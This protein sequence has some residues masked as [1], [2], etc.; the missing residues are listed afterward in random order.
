MQISRTILRRIIREEVASLVEAPVSRTVD[1]EGRPR[2][3]TRAPQKKPKPAQSWEH[4]VDA[5]ARRHREQL[6]LARGVRGGTVAMDAPDEEEDPDR[7]LP[8]TTSPADRAAEN[9][10]EKKIAAAKQAT[11]RPLS[12]PKRVAI[13]N[14]DSDVLDKLLNAYG[15]QASIQVGDT[16]LGS[17]RYGIVYPGENSEY[18]PVAVKLTL[19]A[20][21]VNAYRNIKALK[22][23]LESLD[24]E[25]GE[26]LPTILDIRTIPSPP[27]IQRTGTH[28]RSADFFEQEGGQTYK[29]FIIQ[30]E[31]LAEV[32]TDI[33]SDVFGVGSTVGPGAG[34][35]D[36]IEKRLSG[37][38]EERVAADPKYVIK[39]ADIPDRVRAIKEYLS[40]QNI[41]VALEKIFDKER[42]EN[43]VAAIQADP[44]PV[45][46]GPRGVLPIQDKR[47]FPP[48]REIEKL[49]PALQQQYLASAA[50]SDGHRTSLQKIHRELANKI[51]HIFRKYVKDDTLAGQVEASSGFMLPLQMAANV[52]MPQYDPETI[53]ADPGLSSAF[54]LPGEL[55]T[56]VGKNLYNRLKKLEQHNVRYGDVHQDNLMMRADGE[57]VVADIGLFLFGKEGERGYAGHIAERFKKLAGLI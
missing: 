19:D 18:G 30:M 22:D 29:V 54:M 14:F 36:P 39:N 27:V 38:A 15:Q 45:T 32:P 5:A 57:L 44:G 17:G 55:Q 50:A 28:G 13:T 24:P 1:M 31:R 53:E 25:A 21:E 46:E 4:P 6:A 3:K 16:P 43:L 7:T 8:P 2:P 52:R 10:K 34:D 11:P 48:F 40:I 41:Y 20:Q 23:S 33:R 35:I 56:K 42:W 47:A 51:S 37:D 12:H 49:L 9:E 26:V